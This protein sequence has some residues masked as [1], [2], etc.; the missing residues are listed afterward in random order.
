MRASL[1]ICPD[2]TNSIKTQQHRVVDDSKSTKNKKT[3]PQK[4]R[5][6]VEYPVIEW[7]KKMKEL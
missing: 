3:D 5:S 7:V 2:S 6:W 4:R 1:V